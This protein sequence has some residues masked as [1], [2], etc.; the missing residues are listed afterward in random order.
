MATTG[1]PNRFEGK[2][3]L[4]T[5]AASGM[6][7]SCSLLFASEGA[8]VIGFDVN[9]E[10]LAETAQLVSEAGGK[11]ESGL[12]DVSSRDAC[13]A[14]VDKAVEAF[15]K[16]DI[17]LNVA[18]V[19]PLGHMLDV[20]EEQW[21]GVIGVNTSSVFFLSQAAIPHLIESGGNIVN[22]ASNAGLMGQAYSVS[23]CAS[24]GAV[25]QLTRSMAMEFMKKPIRINAVCPA[26]TKTGIT[27]NASLPEDVD[28]KLM[29][30]FMGM[31]GLAE[32]EEIAD[33][34]AF[35]ASDAA[36]SMHGSIISADNG[37]MAG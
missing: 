31:R 21:N 27:A 12:C 10:G 34:I 5:G 14:A 26:G 18:G 29:A 36:K 32:A 30:G 4:I 16:L 8:S 33:V 23:Y 22:V 3:T 25:V 6:G 35:V 1:Q 9:E 20:T 2:A 19:A 37:V 28:F 11:F 17:L 24:K 15:G 7:R 13:F